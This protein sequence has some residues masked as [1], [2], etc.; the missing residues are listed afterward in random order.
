[1]K[2]YLTILLL[3]ISLN[4][5]SQSENWKIYNS[6]NSP[7]PNNKITSSVVD[8]NNK[9]FFAS[10]EGLIVFDGYK[11]KTYNTKNSEIPSNKILNITVDNF[12]NKWIST[13]NGLVL[14]LLMEKN[15]KYIK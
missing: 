13:T 5:I 4:L 8:K 12:N 9:M 2:N 1:M 6:L 15:V 14:F 11:W 3:F 7:L 10:H